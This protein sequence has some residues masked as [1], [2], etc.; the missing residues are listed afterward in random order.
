MHTSIKI[1]KKGAR[2][3]LSIFIMLFSLTKLNAQRRSADISLENVPHKDHFYFSVERGPILVH[4]YET[5]N[6]YV[7]CGDSTLYSKKQGDEVQA[8]TDCN[9]SSGPGGVKP[10]GLMI[11]AGDSLLFK[12]TNKR[13]QNNFI[14]LELKNNQKITIDSTN[15]FMSPIANNPKEVYII[16]RAARG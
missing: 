10:F 13:V 11:A 14:I 7:I 4:W 16:S 3:L 2:L 12:F 1:R 9:K 8:E 6:Q 5:T 15:V